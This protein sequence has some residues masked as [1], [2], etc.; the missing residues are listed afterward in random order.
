MAWLRTRNE[1]HVTNDFLRGRHFYASCG[2]FFRRQYANAEE[3]VAD[4]L[5]N[6]NAVDG[7][8][9]IHPPIRSMLEGR[10]SH[11]VLTSASHRVRSLGSISLLHADKPFETSGRLIDVV[12][13]LGNRSGNRQ[14]LEC[15]IERVMDLWVS[16]QMHVITVR[17]MNAHASRRIDS[18]IYRSAAIPV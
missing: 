5:M 15:S 18:P 13:I 7:V 11:R 9:V 4:P 14:A 2:R 17:G 1:R 3:F 10:P 12:G 6:V 16:K 8:H